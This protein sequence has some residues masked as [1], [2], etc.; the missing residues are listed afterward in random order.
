MSDPLHA[1]RALARFGAQ[2]WSDSLDGPEG[3]ARWEELEHARPE[4]LA[5]LTL[6]L[7]EGADELAG[8]LY[9]GLFNLWMTRGPVD[10]GIPLGE[11]ILARPGLDDATRARVERA[12]GNLLLLAGRLADAWQHLD[13]AEPLTRATGD[14]AL[15]ARLWLSMAIW[16]Q[17][18]GEPAA[19]LPVLERA[20]ALP[21]IGPRLAG[22]IHT[23]RGTSLYTLG[24]VPAALAADELSLG[25]HRAA[26]NLR[27]EALTLTNIA[28][29]HL[30]G[31]R[32]ARAL[33]ALDEALP[34]ARRI[35]NLRTETDL[36]RILAMALVEAED[37]DFAAADPRA[38]RDTRRQEAAARAEA[39]VRQL[40]TLGQRRLECLARGVWAD[41]LVAL[42][43]PAEALG[44]AELAVTIAHEIGHR[45]NEGLARAR[46]AS[47][48]LRRGE[49]DMFRADF[50]AAEA[51]LAATELRET[52][53]LAWVLR[54]H[55][56]LDQGED[57]EA[58]A[59][60]RRA[61]ELAEP[62]PQGEGMGRQ[63]IA[64]LTRALD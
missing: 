55:A 32:T 41:T 64:R 61:T 8:E 11:R 22:F 60:L 16:Y 25:L 53:V 33:Q 59:C 37:A 21:G 29:K 30:D 26:G 49:M 28:L 31:G 10:E 14:S 27:M 12:L 20:L 57:A 48:H 34:L 38:D 4:L 3:P 6:C 23:A 5:A 13:G 62:L 56:E 7:D 24:D 9:I 52:R 15:L 46:R 39:A 1:A 54:G 36:E 42:D 58:R 63:A 35:G 2:A 50:A 18:R 51:L 17:E 47:I 45:R 40:V 43:R 19:S 44:E